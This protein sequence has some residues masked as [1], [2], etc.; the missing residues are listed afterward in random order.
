VYIAAPYGEVPQSYIRRETEK[1]RARLL[2]M[3]GVF[4]GDAK[5]IDIAGKIVII[6]DDGVATGQTLFSTIHMLRKQKPAKLI[7]AV[8]VASKEALNKL[9]PMVDDIVCPLVPEEFWGVGAFY[10]DFTQVDDSTA[11]EL[12]Q[13]LKEWV[14]NNG[15]LSTQNMI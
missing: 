3:Y 7:I 14:R 1:I 10:Q 4:L 11:K 5:P 8:P 6:I 12:L 13:K 2:E 9:A 15:N